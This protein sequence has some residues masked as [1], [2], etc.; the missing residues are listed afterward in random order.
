MLLFRFPIVKIID[1]SNKIEELEAS[2]NPFGIMVLAHLK[3]LATKKDYQIR[4]TWKLSL[5]KMLYNKGYSREDILNLYRFIDWL[6]VLPEELAR[7]FQDEMKVFEEGMNVAYITT[8]ERIGIE[9]GRQE[10]I[11]EGI[12]K[13]LQEGLQKGAAQTLYNLYC[14]GVLTSEQA[15]ARLEKLYANKSLS[16]EI[17]QE[18]INKISL[19]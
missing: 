3:T 7:Q 13:G 16:E 17:Y 19:S 18:F 6:M 14:E 15:K 2:R 5:V 1:Y 10:G 11:Q 4:F 12:K 9:K 8:A